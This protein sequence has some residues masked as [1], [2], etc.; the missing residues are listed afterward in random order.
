MEANQAKSRREMEVDTR[1]RTQEIK[2]ELKLKVKDVERAAA[3]ARLE[4]EEYRRKIQADGSLG[5]NVV[6]KMV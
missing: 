5:K 2:N 6:R 4:R 1:R 3:K